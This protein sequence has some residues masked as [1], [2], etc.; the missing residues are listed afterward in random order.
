M[1]DFE[2]VHF[3]WL[4]A[5]CALVWLAPVRWQVDLI[6]AS[7]FCF[8]GLHAPWSALWLLGASLLVY[9]CYRA[10][11]PAR[12][13][14]TGAAVLLIATVFLVY[15]GIEEYGQPSWTVPAMIGLSYYS[16]RHIHVLLEMYKGNL[17]SM[18][19]RS[20]L[21][22]QLF[23][24]TLVAGPIHRYPNFI[25]QC[26]RRRWDRVQLAGGMER[27]LYGYAK[28]I[29]IGNYL[30]DLELGALLAPLADHFAG[31]WLVSAKDWLYLYA[32]FS[33]YTDVALGFSLILG[34]R[35]EENF[36]APL[37]A[38][39]LIDFWQ[40]WHITLSSWC[41][42]YVFRPVQALTR[43]QFVAVSAAMVTL[44]IWHQLSLYYLL[45]GLY[46]ALGITLCRLYQL[47][48]DPL[49]LRRLPSSL[50]HGVT[51]TATFAWLTGGMP[52]ITTLL[53]FG[54]T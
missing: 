24:P 42:D 4:A 37:K 31:L 39:N 48:D 12:P 16:C 54:T 49:G 1:T 36:N 46:H 35:I 11:L 20:Y 40:R 51:R 13:R 43:N 41:R 5:T 14:L 25:R 15:Q 23:L 30:L 50:R 34:F 33:G 10:P 26:E 29:V 27:I 17:P 44:G 52:L 2:I 7:T 45:W 21:H 19:L 28:I 9:A 32:V 8:I 53:A 6:A 3:L 38:V 47:H 22:Y 18:S